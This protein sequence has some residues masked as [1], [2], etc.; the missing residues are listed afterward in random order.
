MVRLP[1][2][3]A[4]TQGMDTL[5]LRAFESIINLILVSMLLKLF[6]RAD[7]DKVKK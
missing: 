3:P 4:G 2:F 5:G 6:T 7:L 1:R